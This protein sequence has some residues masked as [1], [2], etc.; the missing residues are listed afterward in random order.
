MLDKRDHVLLQ[1]TFPAE[2][3]FFRKI[4]QRG[5][6]LFFAYLT[7][8]YITERLDSV[9]PAWELMVVNAYRTPAAG[10]CIVRLV[11]KGV[12]RDGVG[13]HPIETIEKTGREVGE[14]EKSAAT[15]ALRRAARQFGIGRYLLFVPGHVT[16]VEQL[17]PWLVDYQRPVWWNEV[18][19]KYITHP[20]FKGVASHLL[21]A[22][23]K[24]ANE[25][26]LG[27]LTPIE[28]ALIVMAENYPVPERNAS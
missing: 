5:K 3:H 20:H 1:K 28:D 2:A 6:E 26:I 24:L 19:T 7:E 12:T 16:T 23:R 15:D 11:I 8:E 9:D 17:K 4:E 22:M 13:Q 25:G 18:Y 27:R 21:A 10:V 14:V